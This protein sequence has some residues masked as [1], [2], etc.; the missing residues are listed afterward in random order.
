[1]LA[2]LRRGARVPPGW[3]ELGIGGLWAATAA[4]WAAGLLPARWVAVLLG[5]SWLVVAAGAVDVLHRRLPDALTLPALPAALVLLVPAGAAAVQAGAAG[6]VAA[7]AVHG[8][9]HL[10]D[11]RAVGAGDVKLAASLGAVL[12]ALGWPALV[13]GAVL[14]ALLTALV[15]GAGLATGRLARGAAVPH[16]PSMLLATWLVTV[17]LLVA[18]AAGGGATGSAGGGVAG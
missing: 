16:G 17:W 11:R 13:L 3:C 9:V 15:A 4:G 5:L 7:V 1:V 2:R 10:L 6:A 8:A 14:A 12:A 18:G